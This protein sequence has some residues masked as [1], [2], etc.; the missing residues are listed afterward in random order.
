MEQP[1]VK[2]S[3][4]YALTIVQSA[5]LQVR[6]VQKEVAGRSKASAELSSTLP[7]SMMLTAMSLEPNYAGLAITFYSLSRS[8]T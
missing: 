1:D 5:G 3:Y 7:P 2:L 8:L 4:I 6:C